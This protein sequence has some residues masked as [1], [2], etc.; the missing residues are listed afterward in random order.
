MVECKGFL[1][2]A[3]CVRTLLFVPAFDVNVHGVCESHNAAHVDACV[4]VDPTKLL[5][6]ALALVMQ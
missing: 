2:E 1:C 6:E 3:F 4:A 5:I